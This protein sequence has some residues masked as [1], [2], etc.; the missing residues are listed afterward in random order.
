MDASRPASFPD[1]NI[2]A[3]PPPDAP[4]GGF[5]ARR[6]VRSIDRSK[7][8]SIFFCAA[9]QVL[10][11]VYP[12]SCPACNA[13][14]QQNGFLCPACWTRLTLIERPFC[15]R[16]GA[17]FAQDL[18]PG[19]ISPQALAD[20]PVW[21]RAR[22]VA[23]Y[24]DG[25]ARRLVHALKYGDRMDLA[26]PMG[27]WM[28][29]AGAELLADADALAP[30]PLHRGRLFQRRFNQAAALAHAVAAASGVPCEPLLLARK[31]ATPP[32]VG[33]S[34]AQRAQNVQGVFHAPD[35]ARAHGRRIVLI[36]DVMTSGATC[37]AA[38]RAL[39]RAG[40]ARVDA[41]TFGRVVSGF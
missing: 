4:S 9:Q 20:P 31:R 30:V 27:L 5:F 1:A 35:P 7:M 37:N 15:E 19:L 8:R 25:P 2:P 21:G 39:L 16:S 26:G 3:P 6:F 24:E 12:P 29:R 33:L 34:R 22:A 18:G 23:V 32:Q 28:A 38:A 17:P 10:D 13:A 41:L 14:V 36:D 11:L 40:A